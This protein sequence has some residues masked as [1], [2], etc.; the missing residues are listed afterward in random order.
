MSEILDCAEG[1]AGTCRN[2]AMIDELLERAARLESALMVILDQV[3]Y[4]IGNC[5]LTEMVG[6][7]LPKPLI[8][9]AREALKGG[10][11]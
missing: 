2:E 6:A 9:L 5:G 11:S 10:E 3:D 4:T 8:D 7:V 1:G